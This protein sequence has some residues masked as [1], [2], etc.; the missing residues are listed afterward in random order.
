MRV[1]EHIVEF[2]E[3]AL[4]EGYFEILVVGIRGIEFSQE[5]LGGGAIGILVS[6][7]RIPD[8]PAVRK[9]IATVEK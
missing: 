2:L 6:I 3:R 1:V 5:T 8:G 7:F 9:E 4:A